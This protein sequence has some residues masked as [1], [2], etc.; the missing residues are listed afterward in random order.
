M[1]L[2]IANL[3]VKKCNVLTKELKH[4]PIETS[5]NIIEFTNST[6]KSNLHVLKV[7]D[8]PT[9]I[10]AANKV[11][12]KH[13]YVQSVKRK[14]E[15]LHKKVQHFKNRF[16]NLF[17]K[18]MPS[19]WD[20]NGNLISQEAYDALVVQKKNEEDKFGDLYRHLKGHNIMEKINEYFDLLSKFRL[21]HKNMQLPS[22]A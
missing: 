16:T 17:N 11:I 18:G 21:I 22:Y 14:V 9:L 1:N 6:T 20:S 8:R 10:M 3:S 2:K 5:Q 4:G 19:F 12:Y 7:N 13:I 15:N